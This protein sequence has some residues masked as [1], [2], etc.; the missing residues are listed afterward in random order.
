MQDDDADEG[1]LKCAEVPFD[2]AR[3]SHRCSGTRHV[4]SMSSGRSS[5]SGRGPLAGFTAFTGFGAR[6]G[7]LCNASVLAGLEWAG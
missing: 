2:V 7:K 4:G 5:V 6:A 1:W 3:R